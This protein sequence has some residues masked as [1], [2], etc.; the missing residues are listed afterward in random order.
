MAYKCENCGKGKVAGHMVSHAKNRLARLFLPNLQ[1]LKVLK[2]GVV[3]RVKFCTSC[4]KRLRK[5][6]QIGAFSVI[7]LG[8]ATATLTAPAKAV[9]ETLV[10]ESKEKKVKEAVRLAQGKKE[11]AKE[12]LDIASIVG[13]KS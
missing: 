8:A 9:I 4:I 5:D 7:K 11:K 13:K 10:K 6:G 1:K 3:V 2:A 12:T